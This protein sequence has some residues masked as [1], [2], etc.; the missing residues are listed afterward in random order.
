MHLQT[1]YLGPIFDLTQLALSDG[2]V[3]LKQPSQTQLALSLGIVRMSARHAWL[4][5]IVL[6]TATT[7]IDVVRTSRAKYWCVQRPP[8]AGGR[9]VDALAEKLTFAVVS[10]PLP[11]VEMTSLR[12][13]G[14][15]ASQEP[16]DFSRSWSKRFSAGGKPTF[17]SGFGLHPVAK[18]VPSTNAGSKH[19]SL[20]FKSLPVGGRGAS[21]HC[22]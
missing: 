7:G 18:M 14:V 8:A 2:L 22:Y 13:S 19:F 10:F 4:F 5:P 21:I 12:S 15:S 17:C 9:A 6:I 11:I 16:F 3:S 20:M 1:E